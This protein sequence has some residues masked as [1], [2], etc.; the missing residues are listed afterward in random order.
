MKAAR[1][2]DPLHEVF[3]IVF[4]SCS[5]S[6]S[7]I[8]RFSTASNACERIARAYLRANVGKYLPK[9]VKQI[10]WPA[11][12]QLAALKWA[13]ELVGP[14]A[15]TSVSD[16]CIAIPRVPAAV[17]TILVEGGVVIN[18]VQLVKASIQRTPGIEV[19]VKSHFSSVPAI[20]E[21]VCTTNMVKGGD[22]WQYVY[23]VLAGQWH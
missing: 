17:A 10:T 23:S 21:A 11:E 16:A 13:V 14:T 9:A 12:K 15:T 22:L 5:T 18:E 2:V 7:I 8:A 6:I 4:T 20:I 19:W 1:V 3:S